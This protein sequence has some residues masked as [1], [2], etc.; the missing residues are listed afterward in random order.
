MERKEL[1]K[2]VL[3]AAEARDLDGEL[4]ADIRLLQNAYTTLRDMEDYD[5]PTT[6]EELN[7]KEI[8]RLTKERVSRAMED[9]TLH[10]RFPSTKP[11]R[12]AISGQALGNGPILPLSLAKGE[13][14]VLIAE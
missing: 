12:D 1:P 13:T 8:E 10:L 9:A 5:C 4:R 14:R 3:I 11:I 7:T 2:T 6:L